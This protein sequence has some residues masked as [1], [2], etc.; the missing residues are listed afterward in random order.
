MLPSHA[1]WPDGGISTEAG[2]AEM[3]QR[4]ETGKFKVASHLSEFFEEFRLYHRR[5]GVIV[6]ERDDI[7]S[8]VRIAVMAKRFGKTMPLGSANV[9]RKA[10]LVADGIDFPLF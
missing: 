4:M 8:A 6:K 1:T 7:L 2:I 3:Q 10:S 9:A 5:E